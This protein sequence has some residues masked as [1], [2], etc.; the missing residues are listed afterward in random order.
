MLKLHNFWRSSASTRVRIA[1]GLKG[2]DWEY[3]PHNLRSGDHRSEGYLARNPQGLVP[4]LELDGG[5]VI[6][7]SLAIIEYLDD[8]HPEPALLPAEPLARARVRSL[9]MAIACELHPLNNLSVL[10]YVKTGVGGDDAAIEAWYRHWA[11]RTFG[12][13]E[14]RLASESETGR[15]CHGEQPGLA[16]V[17][18]VAQVWRN[19]QQGLDNTIYSTIDRIHQAC[20][21]IEAFAVAHPDRQ[22]DAQ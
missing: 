19:D 22:P 6:S 18:L 21:E 13:L 17:C 14:T 7:Q 12:A 15:F 1:L 5:E 4:A 11:E 9:A 10:Q 2:L 20:V 3:V 8:V 16:D